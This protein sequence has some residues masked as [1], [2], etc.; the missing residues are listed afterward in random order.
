MRM[1]EVGAVGVLLAA[2]DTLLQ[3]LEHG[4]ASCD[5]DKAK[6]ETKDHCQRACFLVAL[7]HEFV[8]GDADGE[9]EVV[10]MPP[11]DVSAKYAQEKSLGA[12][13]QAMRAF[14]QN[15]EFQRYALL[16][17]GRLCIKNPAN[18]KF[19]GAEALKVV[20][21][22]MAAH[23]QDCEFLGC[24]I[25]SIMSM[26]S[27]VE[28]S[29]LF[30]AEKLPFLLKLSRK[31]KHNG[32]LQAGLSQLLHVMGKQS[33]PVR[34]VM[35]RSGCAKAVAEIVETFKESAGEPDVVHEA[36]AALSGLLHASYGSGTRDIMNNILKSTRDTATSATVT[37]LMQVVDSENPVAACM[38]DQGVMQ[39]VMN[40]LEWR[41]QNGG[42]IAGCV[43]VMRDLV[44]LIDAK[45][46]EQ[47]AKWE[48]QCW[49]L[50]KL[51]VAAMQKCNT[52][53]VKQA[54]LGPCLSLGCCGPPRKCS[55]IGHF[56]MSSVTWAA[57]LLWSKCFLCKKN[58]FWRG[59][60][61][62]WSRR[63]VRW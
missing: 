33:R 50:V 12:I 43:V 38:L 5:Y 7:V 1:W 8:M 6:V 53:T 18:R 37:T 41:V 3:H 42:N 19:F 40:A 57:S 54:D 26:T 60:M 24:G 2:M 58:K 10:D 46:E 15:K 25:T 56:G 45:N 63:T 32:K 44:E 16:A 23:A 36:C 52:E 61:M 35:L 28:K 29:M 20:F 34:E 21:T 31:N 39:A 13:P 11:D 62:V 17:L 27:G 30:A 59:Q 48:P 22:A 49:R 51:I 55:V 14:P 47:R 9:M 4:A